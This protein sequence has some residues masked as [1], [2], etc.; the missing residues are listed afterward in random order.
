MTISLP[1]PSPCA[2]H[3]PLFPHYVFHHIPAQYF[4]SSSATIPPVPSTA[5]MDGHDAHSIPSDHPPPAPLVPPESGKPVV[6][7]DGPRDSLSSPTSSSSSSSPT[8]SASPSA[9]SSSGSEHNSPY[10]DTS[11]TSAVITSLDDVA[12]RIKS[13]KN[14]IVLVGAGVSVSAGIPDFRSPET[15]LYANLQRFNLPAPEAI[16]D[17]QFFQRK[18]EPFFM[19]CKDLYPDTSSTSQSPAHPPPDRLLPSPLRSLSPFPPPPVDTLE[20]I[21]G[22]PAEMIVEAHGSFAKSHCIGCHRDFPHS[23]M[24]TRVRRG[25]VVRC[26]E[27]GSLVKPDIVFFGEGLPSR[28]FQRV[29]Q[30]SKPPLPR[31]HLGVPALTPSIAPEQDLPECDLLIVI[32]TS[33]QVHPFA[34]LISHVGPDCPRVLI[35]KERVGEAR[36]A[37]DDEGFRFPSSAEAAEREGTRDFF[38][39]GEADLGVRELAE[40]LG[41]T[42][43]LEEL[44][45]THQA[46]LKKE[47]SITHDDNDDT[48]DQWIAAG[49]PAVADSKDLAEDM[50]AALAEDLKKVR[51][52]DT[53]SE[54]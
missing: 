34:S 33:L 36:Y 3:F 25:E 6:D 17:L 44:I 22:L 7:A 38:W 39:Q 2:L 23:E 49:T 9:S 14:V 43:E 41:W 8:R 11:K 15:G 13:A 46:E 51:I 18:P 54:L 10:F 21:S 32:G 42:D 53:K 1:N 40:K 47:W 30:V 4:G 12:E 19:L 50:L 52:E 16:F 28:F 20:T 45:R 31:H 5:T 37:W 27:C 35:N 29:R 26:G 24:L 48:A